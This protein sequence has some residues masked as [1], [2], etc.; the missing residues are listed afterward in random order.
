MN[1]GKVASFLEDVRDHRGGL[2][3]IVERLREIALNSGPAITEEVKY[4]GLLFSSGSSFCGVF[5]GVV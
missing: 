4:G 5:C 3:A 2:H 1:S